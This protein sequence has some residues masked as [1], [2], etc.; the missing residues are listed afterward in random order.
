MNTPP[1][2]HLHVHTEYS[3]SDGIT[4][5]KPLVA[6]AAE[7]H[8]PAVA[9]TDRCNLF[10]AVKFYQAAIAIGIKPIIGVDLE[11]RQWRK[12]TPSGQLL[13][14]SQ[15]NTG[16]QAL[17]RLITRVYADGQALGRPVL[18]PAWLQNECADLVAI[19]PG[20]TGELDT[21]TLHEN[22]ASIVRDRLRFWQDLFGDRFYLGVQHT[23]RQDDDLVSMT[24]AIAERESVPI[25]ATNDVRFLYHDEFEAHEARVCINQGRLLNDPQ[26]P[27]LYS[28]QQYLRSAE[29][30]HEC[31]Q[32]LPEAL[33]NSIE[34]ARRCSA[35]MPVGERFLPRFPLADDTTEDNTLKQR[36][37][38]SIRCRLADKEKEQNNQPLDPKRRSEYSARLEYEL[39]VIT[40]MGFSGY[41]LIV[42]DFVTWAR[43][44]DIPVGPGRGSGAGSLVAWSLGIT[45]L[46]PIHYNLLFERFLNP[47]RVSMPDFDIDLCM[48]R[49]EN[50]INY[51]TQKYSSDHV[52]QIISFGTMA[53]RAAVRDVG[54]VLGYA[55]TYV[56]QL[57]KLI[58][59]DIGITLEAA[60]KE[61]PL[62][63]RYQEDDDQAIINMACKLEGIVRNIGKHAS[64]IVISPEKLTRYTAMYCEPG[65]TVC[66]TTQFDKDD[67]EEIGLLKFDL[68]GLRTLTIIDSAVRPINVKREQNGQSPLSMD[69]LK[70]DDTQ[71][72]DRIKTGETTAVFQLESSGMKDL[73]RRLQPNIFDDIIA[74]L[75]MFRP[76]PLG[77]GMVDD[78]V[79]RKLGRTPVTYPHPILEPILK[80][81]YGVILYQEQVM[82]I[83]QV[84]A[85][86][87]LGGADLLRRAMGKKK[88][89]EMA[90]LRT[91][92]IAG[93][94]KR[95]IDFSTAS[96]I[97]DQVE[98]F[99]G[100]GF[101]KSHSTAYALL[102][103]QTAW[104]KVHY[105]GNFMAAVL[106]ADMGNT[107]KM[108]RLVNECAALGIHLQPPCV[109][110]CQRGFNAIDETYI[111]YGLGAIKG[112][113][114]A[115]IESIIQ[116]RHADG[117]YSDLFNFCRRLG[118][119]RINRRTLGALICSGACDDLGPSRSV[120]MASL[121]SALQEAEQYIRDQRSGQND[122]F[123]GVVVNNSTPR[124]AEAPVWTPE[125]KLAEE[126]NTLGVYLSDHPIR[127]YED[128]LSRMIGT[129][130]NELQSKPNQT[131]S[132]AG[133]IVGVRTIKTRKGRMAILRLDDRT[134]QTEVIVR[135]DLYSAH[136]TLIQ[137]DHLLVVEGRIG[138]DD[139]SGELSIIASALYDLDQARTARARC[140]KVQI[141]ADAV[142]DGFCARLRDVLQPYR[143]G[144]IP[145][146]FD[147]IRPDA[148]TTLYPDEQWRVHP[149]D[150]LLSQLRTL[151]GDHAVEL[152]Y[153]ETS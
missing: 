39:D 45:A 110:R 29:E 71:T 58:P 106:S 142:T 97:F 27:R 140:L 14:L 146:R 129:R 3:L 34:I 126:K 51:I 8:M 68:L 72:Y 57:A 88:P 16:L 148:T 113:G 149:S 85:G 109:N 112:V 47:E 22:D 61:E 38:D 6:R 123:G 111:D 15:N 98:K 9:I 46:D 135:N 99:A 107:D 83:A 19:S 75:S 23:A 90:K 136:Q 18:D 152:E 21:L 76:G 30:M 95:G 125:E 52:A 96:A 137:R 36:V 108:V 5:I 20:L 70:T 91:G 50:V 80:T 28:A 7:L 66:T 81:T 64:G 103:Y 124:F 63:S 42:A 102:S 12:T 77:A 134:A 132:I 24:V 130:L 65:A 92:F 116:E 144:D 151:I 10:A 145:I 17:M 119:R 60:L 25:V 74:L 94:V 73:I 86:Y 115:V 55:Y 43:D 87:S 44:N 118:S 105:P 78:F 120:M 49:R 1:F 41:F 147:Y 56:D 40:R 82:H 150:K 114:D 100:Y 2:V 4:R 26:R 133:F 141:Q 117:H 139:F 143:D 13:L 59:N 31:F 84:M 101:N 153:G 89:E 122:L 121:A 54:R 32:E 138:N 69:A 127:R 37:H 33:Q 35:S 131:V 11:L 48:D 53:A 79:S 67:L 104:L 93:A 62:K 128:E